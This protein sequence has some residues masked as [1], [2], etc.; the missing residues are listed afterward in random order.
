[1]TDLLTSFYLAVGFQPLT[2]LALLVIASLL[3]AVTTVMALNKGGL[4]EANPVMRWAMSVMNPILALVLIKAIPLIAIY[5]TLQDN[6][7]YVPLT[8]LAYL[9]V[10][11][12]NLRMIGRA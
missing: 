6:V 2:W 8:V 7:L 3:D 10:V 11:A 4:Q 12:W 9:C 1:M 5:L